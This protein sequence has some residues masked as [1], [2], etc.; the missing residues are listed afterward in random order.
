MRK[1]VNYHV[2][3]YIK[4]NVIL[5]KFSLNRRTRCEKLSNI[6]MLQQSVRFIMFASMS[7][8]D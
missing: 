8:R 7:K 4:S 5:N 2:W 3:Q 1:L 6:L